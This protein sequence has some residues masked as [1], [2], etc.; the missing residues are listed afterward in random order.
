LIHAGTSQSSKILGYVR[1]LSRLAAQ[2]GC[3]PAPAQKDARPCA[4][5]TLTRAVSVACR[6]TLWGPDA[7]PSR[8]GPARPFVRSQRCTLW[9]ASATGRL[10]VPLDS[11]PNVDG[12]CGFKKWLL[13]TRDALRGLITV[14]EGHPVRAGLPPRRSQRW[15]GA[16]RRRGNRGFRRRLCSHRVRFH[17]PVGSG[18]PTR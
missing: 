11:G 17:G 9:L 6:L 12:C 10:Y 14:H 8:R 4:S 2:L 15:G 18:S 7:R 1:R 16:F 5:R 13:T 3:D